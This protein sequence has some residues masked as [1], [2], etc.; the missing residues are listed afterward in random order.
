MPI[1]YTSTG[2]IDR[3]EVSSS[4]I[5]SGS[6]I[7]TG[8]LVITGSVVV[9]TGGIRF[10]ATAVSSSDVNTLDDYEEG[11]WTPTFGSG[12]NWTYGTRAGTYTKIGNTVCVA[13][14]AASAAGTV[15]TASSNAQLV[16]NNLPFAA[17]NITNAN[18]F[19]TVAITAVAATTSIATPARLTPNT[20]NLS[21]FRVTSATNDFLGV[22][23]PQ[24]GLGTAGIV[25]GCITYTTN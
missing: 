15:F 12:T 18:F 6:S 8:S 4:A 3:L 23:F 13:F 17:R 22:G 25:Q 20:T 10:P 19:S 21:F 16:I 1:F 7:I 24:N 5:F 9:G 2:S 11:V 14:Y